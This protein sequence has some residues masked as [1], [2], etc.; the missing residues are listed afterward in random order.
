M[1]KKQAVKAVSLLW[2][3][4]LV[5]ALCAFLTQVILARQLGPSDFGLFSAALATV[6]LLTPIAGFGIAQY[7]LKVFGQEGWD[8]ERWLPATFIFV[9]ICV[10]FTLV[11]LVGWAF[12]GPHD[13]T[14]R[15]LLLVLSLCLIGQVMVELV[16][17]KFQ[18]E[19]KYI[20]LS[21]WQLLPHLLRFLL[22]A[23]LAIW[24]VDFMNVQFAAFAYAAVSM[25]LIALAGVQLW[26]M[27]AGGVDL[28]G[29]VRDGTNGH[30]Q[31]LMI[32]TVFIEAWPFGLA[33]LLY[34][35]YFQS[36]IIFVKYIN[37][38]EAAG[39]Y[40]V[41]FTIMMATYLLPNVIFQKFLLPK[42]HRWANH[43]RKRFYHVYRKGNISMLILGLIA[44]CSIWLSAPS[45]IYFLFGDKYDEAIFLLNIL[46]V[47]CPVYFVAI[48]I[49]S[50]LATQEHMKKRVKYMGIVAIFNIVLNLV[51]LP[52][53]GVA[54]AAV[55]VLLSNLALLIMYYRFSEN[56]VFKIEV[57]EKNKN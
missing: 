56:V 53:F 5:G 52:I 41:A 43:D 36:G 6:T 47:S 33:G 10:T 48:S 51:L 26:K 23:L 46:A 30:E 7:W 17:S 42:I 16:S 1:S 13:K 28:K 44:M 20:F 50:T 29:H 39:I 14:M 25:F 57:F 34:M 12:I 9:G 3:G 15:L 8:A 21:L 37:G 4:S 22:V 45:I 31:S 55:S 40:N 2:L 18:L 11:G 32:R 27:I 38:P 49:G 19:E 24:Y 54:G 35:I